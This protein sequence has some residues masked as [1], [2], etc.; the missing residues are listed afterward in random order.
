MAH[1][2]A[3]I[4]ALAPAQKMGN[5]RH[6]AKQNTVQRRHNRHPQIAANGS[7]GKVYRTGMPAH[8]RITEIHC[9]NGRL[10]Y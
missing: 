9:H 3:N 1:Y 4:L 8:G 2:P 10:R 7:T 6:G 5:Y